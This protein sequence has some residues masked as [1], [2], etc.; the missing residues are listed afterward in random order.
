MRKE[1]SFLRYYE[2]VLGSCCQRAFNAIL[3]FVSTNF[4]SL[5]IWARLFR[6]ML[7]F[8]PSVISTS[9]HLL[10]QSNQKRDCLENLLYNVLIKILVQIQNDLLKK[11]SSPPQAS[12]QTKKPR[13]KPNNKL[14]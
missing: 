7:L 6:V 8:P 13:L 11:K 3:F 12:K 2:I 5:R 4:S 14:S 9:T 1:S 10:H